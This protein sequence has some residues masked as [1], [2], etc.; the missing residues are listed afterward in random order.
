MIVGIFIAHPFLTAF[1]VLIALSFLF[2]Y[3]DSP[4]KAK[5]DS[6]DQLSDKVK[7]KVTF[8]FIK[9]NGVTLHTLCAG[10]PSNPLVVLLHGFP[11]FW[12]TW[13][14]QIDDLVNASFYVMIP[15]QRGYNL[16]SKPK[17]I[18]DYKLSLIM[19]DVLGLLDHAEKEKAY[20]GGH[21]WGG[22]V[23]WLLATEHPE[24]FY[25]IAIVNI[26]HPLTFQWY[27]LHDKD[28]WNRSHYV[29]K[30]LLPY[31]PQKY[32]SQNNFELL[33]SVLIGS[34]NP[35]T[36]SS[37]DIRAY[38]LAWNDRGTVSCM[39]NWYRA[40]LFRPR[41]VKNVKIKVPIHLIFGVN[42]KF[43]K[44]EMAAK[45]LEMCENGQLTTVEGATHWVLHE[46]PKKVN[47]VLVDFFK[48]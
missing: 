16:S 14:S 36:F 37:E 12:K 28:Q 29:R 40:Q 6:R 45:S 46:E 7:S 26:G 9:T 2:L 35:G 19:Q 10:N 21:D 31:L 44:Y 13:E 23:A 24:R 30:F 18:G 33:E 15:D 41:G 32:L 27:L 22:A 47:K 3:Q 43:V 8:E 39:V 17:D 34:S 42:D 38:K 25:K 48:S 4:K 11:E 5:H 1:F 20:L